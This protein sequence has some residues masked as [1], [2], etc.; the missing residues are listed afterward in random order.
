LPEYYLFSNTYTKALL[1]KPKTLTMS[2]LF[3]FVS[4]KKTFPLPKLLH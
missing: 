2:A 1:K 3:F 4:L